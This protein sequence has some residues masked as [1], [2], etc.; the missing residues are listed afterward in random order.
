MAN[1][2]LAGQLAARIFIYAQNAA[3]NRSYASTHKGE[4]EAAA[5]AWVLLQKLVPELAGQS[6]N[7]SIKTI[8]NLAIG[9][10]K[11]GELSPPTPPSGPIPVPYPNTQRGSL[12]EVDQTELFKLQSEL[13]NYTLIEQTL[14]NVLKNMHDTNKSIIG[15][16]R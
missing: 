4:A 3:K 7:Q 14:A 12:R 10:I 11:G 1:N 5:T 2:E 15:N 16:M 13:S 9:N 8:V 6:I